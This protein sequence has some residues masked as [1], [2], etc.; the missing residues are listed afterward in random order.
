MAI[1]L[2]KGQKVDLTKTNPG[3]T[4]VVVGLG[5][6]TNR[7]DG[8]KDFDLDSTVF[9]LGENG[10]VGSDSDFVFYNNTTGGNG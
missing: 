8:G 10:K 9:L 5:W 7:Y 1:S 4:K 3:L 2:S 6:D